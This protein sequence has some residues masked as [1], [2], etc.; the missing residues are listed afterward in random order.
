MEKKNRREKKNLGG[1]IPHRRHSAQAAFRQAAFRPGGIPPGGSPPRRHSVKGTQAAFRRRTS[2]H[3]LCLS[4]AST[5][6]ICPQ[7]LFN[8]F[9]IIYY[10]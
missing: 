3:V 2:K 6:R 10:I 7:V 4:L 1:G 9:Y 8:I 5:Q